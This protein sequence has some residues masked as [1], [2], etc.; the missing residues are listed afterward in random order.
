MRLLLIRHG[1]TP[2]NVRGELDTAAPGPGL[3]ALGHAQAVALP[4]AL[5]NEPVG[6]VFAST[7]ARTQQT[8]QPLADALGVPLVVLPGVHEVEGGDFE[9]ATDHES[10]RRYFEVAIAW[11][12]GR[13]AVRMP[14]AEDG[15]AFFDRFDASIARAASTGAETIVVVTH[16]V[17]IRVWVSGTVKNLDPAFTVDKEL[18]N[19]GMVVLEGSPA[20][21]WDFVSWHGEPLGGRTLADELA[22]DPTGDPLD[23]E[24]ST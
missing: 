7:L 24:L 12:G 20:D 23:E 5:A 21:G 13:R 6:A 9:M 16:S 17:S 22:E 14:G 11:G 2:A 18:D 10:Y 8:A 15:D 19:T 1:Q 4:A 3:T